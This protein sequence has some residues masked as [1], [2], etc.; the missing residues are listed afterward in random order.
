MNT[1]KLDLNVENYSQEDLLSLLNLD[2]KE[3]VTYEDI[4]NSTTPFINKYAHENNYDFSNFFQ[5]I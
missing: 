5:K 1:D 2:D 3:D 4:I